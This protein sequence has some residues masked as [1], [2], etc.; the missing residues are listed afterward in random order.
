MEPEVSGRAL[1]VR[2]YSSL[3]NM[4]PARLTLSLWQSCPCVCGVERKINFTPSITNLHP[5]IAHL[6]YAQHI[7]KLQIPSPANGEDIML[8]LNE[9]WKFPEAP[10]GNENAY[11]R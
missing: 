7:P 3:P 4:T 9:Q 1:E 5:A 11:Y 2:D 8:M 10:L 6:I